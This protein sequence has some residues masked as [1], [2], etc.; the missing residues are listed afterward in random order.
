MK[1]ILVITPEMIKS[2]DKIKL[3]DGVAEAFKLYSQ[4]MAVNPPRQVFWVNS[5]WWGI[6]T[7]NLPGTGVSVKIVNIIEDNPSRGLPTINGIVAYLDATTGLPLAIIDAPTLTAYRTAAGSMVSSRLLAP[8]NPST[9]AIIGAGY[10]SLVHME[11]FREIHP[12]LET[13]KVYDINKSRLNRFLVEAG[14]IYKKAEKGSDPCSTVRDSDIV[15]LATTAREPAIKGGCLTPPVHV[16]S[17]GV[18]GPDHRELDE[19]TLSR[20]DVIVV[21][22]LSSVLEEVGDLR[23]PIEKGVIGKD[24]IFEIGELLAGTKQFDRGNKGI[25]VYK[26]VGIAVQDTV[27]A[28]MLYKMYKNE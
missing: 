21:D 19:E 9:L 16:I 1:N 26:S 6:M 8:P 11:F 5:N 12:T 24:E 25:T 20:A 28:D 14:K 2:I 15:L 18:M 27:I 17:I 3:V 22:S 7:A 4:G 13:V 10:Q 23:I